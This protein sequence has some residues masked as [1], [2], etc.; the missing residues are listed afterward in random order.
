MRHRFSKAA[1]Y[2]FAEWNIWKI[3]Y[4]MVK[5][6]ITVA[7]LQIVWLHVPY[8]TLV[9]QRLDQQTTKLLIATVSPLFNLVLNIRLNN[10]PENS[11]GLLTS[12]TLRDLG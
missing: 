4:C 6:L 1:N 12:N 5:R 7:D 8:L 9:M 10:I 11:S 2:S 3:L